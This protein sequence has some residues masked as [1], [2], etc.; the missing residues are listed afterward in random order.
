MSG[1][2]DVSLDEVALEFETGE[3][4]PDSLVHG[5]RVGIVHERF[6]QQLQGWVGIIPALEMSGQRESRTRP[7]DCWRSVSSKL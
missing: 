1:Q 7:A 3:H 6:E 4:V 2:L 5:Q